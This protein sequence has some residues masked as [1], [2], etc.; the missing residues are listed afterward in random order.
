VLKWVRSSAWNVTWLLWAF[1]L[2]VAL[3]LSVIAAV[4]WV[5]F[6]LPW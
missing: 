5:V 1:P 4:G 2:L 6:Y 3:A